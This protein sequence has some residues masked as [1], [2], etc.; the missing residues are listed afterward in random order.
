MP[1]WAWGTV[2]TTGTMDAVL[3][4]SKRFIA[5]DD[6]KKAGDVKFFARSFLNESREHVENNIRQSFNG[7]DADEEKQYNFYID[8]AWSAYS[9]A[10]DGYPQEFAECLTLPEAC[11]LDG[12]DVNITTQEPGMCFEE[13]VS[14]T[15]DGVLS[16]ASKEMLTARCRNCGCTESVASFDALE[17]VECSECGCCEFELIDE[18]EE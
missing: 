7:V 3:A 14:C 2:E 4:F 18:G 16:Y 12:V 13:A 17:D 11:I 9:C 15:R 1:N 6:D 10:I 8:F 5:D